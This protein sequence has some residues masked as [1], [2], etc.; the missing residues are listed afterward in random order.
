MLITSWICDLAAEYWRAVAIL[1]LVLTSPH[2]DSLSHKYI[3]V[4]LNYLS[5]LLTPFICP[6]PGSSGLHAVFYAMLPRELAKTHIP[7]HPG[8]DLQ[9]WEPVF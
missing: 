1:K 3:S 8:F 6:V 9:S 5:I 2:P 7:S 4:G